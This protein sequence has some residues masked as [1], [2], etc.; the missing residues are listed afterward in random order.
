MQERELVKRNKDYPQ[1]ILN[2]INASELISSSTSE[3]ELSDYLSGLKE[4][5]GLNPHFIIM[6]CNTIHLYHNLLQSKINCPII[7]L[8]EEV[9]NFLRN[10]KI[11]SI[12]II[13]TKQTANKLYRFK[14]IETFKPTDLEQEALSQA[15]FD[16]NRGL[17]KEVCIKET[18]AICAKYLSLGAKY[19]LLGCTEFAVMLKDSKLPVINTLDILTEVVIRNFIKLKE[20][21]KS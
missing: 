11:N 2:S 20:V 9:N 4:L 5:D 12:L 10:N 15:I 19:I 16:F 18:E 21:N 7:N 14:K 1:L 8:R 3:Y 6:A 17:N 13:G